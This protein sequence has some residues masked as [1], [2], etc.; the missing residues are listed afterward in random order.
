MPLQWRNE[1]WQGFWRK[2]P[3]SD[4]VTASCS[5]NQAG[6]YLPDPTSP[7]SGSVPFF[8][9]S[10]GSFCAKLTRIR[11]GWSGQGLANRIWPGSKP[12]FRNHRARFWQN[13]TG[14]LPVSHFETRQRSSTDGPDQI[15]PN[16]PGADLVLAHTHSVRFWPRKRAGVQESSGQRFRCESAPACLLGLYSS[17]LHA[18]L[19]DVVL[20]T[21]QTHVRGCELHAGVQ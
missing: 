7:A 13:A 10:H 4:A 9:R 8:Q 12:V 11:S 16:Q 2:V 15:V 18:D 3:E 20:L 21:V 17:S 1:I 5:Q 19:T 6:S 14:P